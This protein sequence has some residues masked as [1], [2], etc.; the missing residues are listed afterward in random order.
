MIAGAAVLLGRTMMGRW[1]NH[2]SLYSA[3]FGISL[4]AYATGLINY[5]PISAESWVIL[6][7]AAVALYLGSAAVL[8]SHRQTNAESNLLVDMRSLRWAIFVLAGCGIVAVIVQAQ[9]TIHEF[10][11]LTDALLKSA[12]QVYALRMRGG[13]G[14]EPY[15]IFVSLAA[16]A[17]SGAYAALRGRLTVPGVLPFAVL[18]AQGILSMQRAGLVIAGIVFV[19]A[20]AYSPKPQAAKFGAAFKW[21]VVAV[22]IAVLGLF[23]LVGGHRGMYAEW[24]GETAELVRLSNYWPDLPSDFVYISSPG[25]TLTQYVEHPELAPKGLFASYTLQSLYRLLSKVGF[26]TNVP[27]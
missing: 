16:C 13:L 11:S 1:L 19:F 9:Q 2:L 17:L 23:F 20:Y 10:G 12:V 25:P 21:T 3:G 14:G 7:S 6:A 26:Q 22:G 8:F 4:A 5:H 27:Y 24:P 18:V 15:L